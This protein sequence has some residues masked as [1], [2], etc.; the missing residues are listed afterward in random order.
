MAEINRYNR[1][2]TP[3]L[4]I[5][6]GPLRPK[7]NPFEGLGEAFAG[8]ASRAAKAHDD[9]RRQDGID[10]AK[11]RTYRDQNGKLAPLDEKDRST[12]YGKA[13][14]DAAFTLWMAEASFDTRKVMADLH[15]KNPYNAAT[16]EKDADTYIEQRFNDVP[17]TER[18]LV[19]QSL[20]SIKEEHLSKINDDVFNRNAE[21]RV[22]KFKEIHK[23]EMDE[24]SFLA[25]SD[26]PADRQRA[27]AKLQ[28]LENNTRSLEQTLPTHFNEESVQ[29]YI[30]DARKNFHASILVG[31][32]KRI[33]QKTG[34]YAAA[35]KHIDDWENSPVKGLDRG[36]RQHAANLA[37]GEVND[38][39][40]IKDAFKSEDDERIAKRQK[41]AQLKIDKLQLAIDDAEA[42][43]DLEE[44]KRLSEE[45][46]QLANDEELAAVATSPAITAQRR[47]RANI[48][49]A[50]KAEFDRL[51]DEEEA[52]E[53]ARKNGI[54][55]GKAQSKAQMR[56]LLNS[57]NFE[58]AKKLLK[59]L[60]DKALDPSTAK[61]WSPVFTALDTEFR[62][63]V[64]Q[65]VEGR[66][67]ADK[68][69]QL[70]ERLTSGESIPLVS[71]DKSNL[72][73]FVNDIVPEVRNPEDV[74]LMSELTRQVGFVPDRAKAFLEQSQRIG[75]NNPEALKM[76]ISYYDTLDPAT[77]EG[78]KPETAALYNYMSAVDAGQ[79][80]EN[81]GAH[82]VNYERIQQ[83]A[84]TIEEA[85][86]SYKLQFG[87]RFSKNPDERLVSDFREVLDDT[88]DRPG[89]DLPGFE[90][91]SIALGQITEFSL[92]NAIGEGWDRQEFSDLFFAVL[93]EYVNEPDMPQMLVEKL[94]AKLNS[95]LAQVPHDVQNQAEIVMNDIASNVQVSRFLGR[96]RRGKYTDVAP[97]KVYSSLPG[98]DGLGFFIEDTMVEAVNDFA[99]A[100]LIDGGL[101]EG[102][103]PAQAIAD[104]DIWLIPI[105]AT[106][107]DPVMQL[108]DGTYTGP[109]YTINYMDDN[110]NPKT[111][112]QGN[113][114]IE[115]R[116][117]PKFDEEADKRARAQ[118]EEFLL[119][120]GAREDGAIG[121][122]LRNP[123]V[124]DAL[125]N[126]RKK[127]D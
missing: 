104:G 47:A 86:E 58:E 92:K 119:N 114:V 29:T 40:G 115:F 50:S 26:K 39:E 71:Q 110:G 62:T 113:E 2:R 22:V 57:G 96:G 27:Q 90:N 87:G 56:T 106:E 54:D 121:A 35:M 37:I 46:R 48:A 60:Q 42:A 66:K 59:D 122:I 78:L 101:I 75:R 36:E 31:D 41:G 111:I 77:R 19:E 70:Y 34:S 124:Y 84:A 97:E 52:A 24:I 112:M 18:K 72:N 116:P 74:L 95:R 117:I 83:N 91:G 118:V 61:D 51:R 80:G 30:G 69:A 107:N 10:D 25:M 63:R 8:I 126:I 33:Y 17:E 7:Q 94:N 82:F 13:Y 38:E 108:K 28:A 85:K 98:A 67:S 32:A 123:V 73:A 79:D 76:A 103:S 55:V 23:E 53:L 3:N 100:G 65:M 125:V 45:M 11:T 93:P 88:V 15:R 9:N 120:N 109:A 44:A 5:S 4:E 49:E 64:K 20:R 68:G 43:G 6:V 99:E 16:F 12:T 89:F 14:N 105:G 102:K 81:V 127:M 1:S 21:K